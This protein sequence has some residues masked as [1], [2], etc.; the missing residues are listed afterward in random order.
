MLSTKELKGCAPMDYLLSETPICRLVSSVNGNNLFMKREDLLPFSFGGNKARIANKYF[1][2]IIAKKYDF[3]ISYG[4]S[5]SNMNRVVANLCKRIE[6]P[7]YVIIP[8]EKNIKGETYNSK[9]LDLLEATIIYCDED[10]VATTIKNVMEE[11]ANKGFKPYY[12]YG[13]EYGKGNEK[14]AIQAYKEV[15]EEIIKQEN[16]KKIHFDYIFLASGTGMTQTGLISG[17]YEKR[18]SPRVVGISIARNQQQ[19]IEKIYNNMLTLYNK[20]DAEDIK[21]IIQFEDQ[22]IADGYGQYNNKIVRVIK[23]V[24]MDDGVALNTTYTGKAFWGM[25]EYIKEK[26][27]KEKNILFINTG[28]TPLFFNDLNFFYEGE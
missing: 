26:K 11:A 22:Y 28:G 9:L 12:I 5:S 17:Q 27:I 24:L 13:N 19:G 6:I 2:E 7:C 21:K 20:K 3:V 8:R 16:D 4:S 1:E 15:Y 14:V 25:L 18:H 10:K 23:E